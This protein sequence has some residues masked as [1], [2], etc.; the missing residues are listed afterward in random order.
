MTS[1]IVLDHRTVVSVSGASADEFLQGLVTVSTLNMNTGDLRYGAL[2]TPQGK[3]IADMLIH[4]SQEGFLLD[5]DVEIA[6]QLLKRLNL[7][8]LRAPVA[9]EQRSDMRV[10]AFGGARDPRSA[11]APARG[12]APG[13]TNPAGDPARYHAA[14]IAAGLPEQGADFAPE[15]V[16][17]ADI[18]MDLN[19]GIDFRKGCFVG[20]EVVSRMKR[21]GITRRRTL[22]VEVVD[23]AAPAPVLAN[24]FEIGEISSV[25]GKQGLARVRIDRLAEA[26]ARNETMTSGGNPVLFDEPSWLAGELAALAE[27]KEAKS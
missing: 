17:P 27:A 23:G 21:R 16:F 1:P 22:K 19:D 4:R 10:V 18:N 9:I 7:F 6:P 25:A 12:I 20:Q 26:L 5:C 24:G 3:V 14:R 2:L 8:K 11:S 13:A 15:E